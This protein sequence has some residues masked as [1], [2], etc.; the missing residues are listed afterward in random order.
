MSCTPDGP[1]ALPAGWSTHASQEV[2][3]SVKI[4]DLLIWCPFSGRGAIHIHVSNVVYSFMLEGLRSCPSSLDGL[5]PAVLW[6]PNDT[7]PHLEVEIAQVVNI[8][9]KK[10]KVPK[11]TIC[12]D[13]NV[14]RPTHLLHSC[15]SLGSK[16][17]CV[18]A[19]I[20]LELSVSVVPFAIGQHYFP[21]LCISSRRSSHCPWDRGE[22]TA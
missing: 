20:A 19:A 14:H 21:V 2:R 13:G 15:S 12:V 9:W 6:V 17:F 1:G 11:M 5:W 7:L 4:E 8:I 16:A 18:G 10:A 22:Q 3:N